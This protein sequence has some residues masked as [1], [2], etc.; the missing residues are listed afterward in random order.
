[1][2]LTYQTLTIIGTI[3]TFLLY[4]RKEHRED[5][6]NLVQTMQIMEDYRRKDMQI[7]NDNHRDDMQIMDEKWTKL[8]GL[9]VEK[10]KG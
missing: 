5:I 8:F 2:D 10:L 1:M 4:M 3:S 9:F 6:R 7:M